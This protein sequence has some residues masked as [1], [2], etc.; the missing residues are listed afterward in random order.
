VRKKLVA[1]EIL[2][3]I[4]V[5]SGLILEN[6][7]HF[8]TVQATT[9]V[10][11]IIATDTTWTKANSPYSLT[12]N[13]LISNG[14]T[15][16]IEAGVTVNLNNYYILV[17]GTL[18][19][20]G[21]PS[22]LININGGDYIAFT[23]FS[24]NWNEQTTTGSI[25]ENSALN[26]VQ[27]LIYASPKISDNIFQNSYI[28][29]TNVWEPSS[30]VYIPSTNASPT[31]SNNI[32][33]GGISIQNIWGYGGSPNTACPQISNNNITAVS[34]NVG[35]G[36]ATFYSTG[37]I[38]NN[39]ISGFQQGLYLYSDCGTLIEGNLII[40]NTKGIVTN[41]HQGPTTPI[42]ENNTVTNN[43]DGFYLIRYFSTATNPVIVNNNIY[44][45][46][47][48]N[49]NLGI[50]DTINATNNW[51]GTTDA[52]AINQTIYD[53]KNDFN[54]GT[55]NFVP[56]LNAPNPAA[57]T[58]PTFTIFASAGTGGS[59][60]PN[61]T[62]S[63]NYGDSQTFTIAANTGYYIVDVTVNGSSVGAIS[64][65]TFTNVQAEYIISAT[66]APTP[67]PSPS[68]SPVIPEFPFFI[69]STCLIGI[70]LIGALLFKRKWFNKT[71]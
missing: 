29:V 26:S 19:S 9:N 41:I 14:A 63:V 12:G 38:S 15:L 59:I 49:I 60:S 16:T 66:F 46:I 39:I 65:Y 33:L 58:I 67:T 21:V 13:V 20:R 18:S 71:V 34:N 36:V 2:I 28:E 27:L 17:N 70:T 42:I 53:F 64:S 7:F 47:N 44:G 40:D 69:I 45:N 4:L 1:T 8:S 55:V 62:V 6:G 35:N 31:I 10:T 52:Q 56:F 61:G 11:G 54:L 51:W 30:M 5:V 48:Y 57:P 37:L 68:P 32:I 24:S 3:S 43:V 23:P 25:I 22:N 50:P